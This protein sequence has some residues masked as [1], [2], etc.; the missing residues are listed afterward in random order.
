MK[1]LLSL[2]QLAAL[3][4]FCMASVGFAQTATLKA[5]STT[6]ATAGGSVALTATVSYEGQPS[7]VGWAIALPEDWALVSVSGTNIP[8]IAP[9]PG[10]TGTLE[11]AYTSSP[12]A[13]AEFVIVVSYAKGSAGAKAVPTVLVRANGKLVTLNPAPVEFSSK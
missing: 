7:A 4:A 11:F 6:L 13:K 9:A 2:R 5:D 8:E 1:N 3:F 12:A 10:A